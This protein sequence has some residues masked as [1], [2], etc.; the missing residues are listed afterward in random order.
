MEIAK[1]SKR[2]LDKEKILEFLE[3]LRSNS[4]CVDIL[5]K[6]NLCRDQKDN[7]F[8]DA[9]FACNADYIISGDKDLLSLNKFEQT[10]IVLPSAFINID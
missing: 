8:L 10:L 2:N 6:F 9:A 5:K 4:I 7:M 3:L 1:K